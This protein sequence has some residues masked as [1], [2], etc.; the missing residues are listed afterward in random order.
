[1][2]HSQGQIRALIPAVLRRRRHRLSDMSAPL[3]GD[4]LYVKLS[5][6]LSQ[7]SQISHKT[8]QALFLHRGG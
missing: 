3:T 8:F 4:H 1:M 2:R 6:K 7:M 5:H